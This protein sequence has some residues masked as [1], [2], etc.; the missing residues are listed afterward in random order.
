MSMG[1]SVGYAAHCCWSNDNGLVQLSFYNFFKF[2]LFR[3]NL[4]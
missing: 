3:N 4:D 2:C 1:F